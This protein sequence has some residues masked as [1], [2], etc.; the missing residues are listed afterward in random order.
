MANDDATTDSRTTRRGRYW[1]ATI[2]YY[3]WKWPESLPNGVDWLYGQLELG[4]LTGYV[5]WQFVVAFSKKATLGTCTKTFTRTGHFE[6]TR[7]DS[8]NAYVTKSETR[9]VGPFE[10][11][12]EPV[13]RNSARDWQRV[14]E[15]AINGQL[16]RI[17]PSVRVHH[18]RSLRAIQGDFAK[19]V[20]MDRI[21]YV[22]YGPTGTGKSFTAWSNAGESAYP[23]DPNT[24]WWSGYRNQRNCVIDEYRG[25]ISISH[26]LR[27]LDR[28]PA[29]FNPRYPVY[30]ETKGSSLPLSVTTFYITSN[31]HPKDWYPDLDQL[32]YAALE[33]RLIITHFPFRVY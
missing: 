19:P 29:L 25:S 23:K 8:A 33:R 20:P 2:P 31:L 9:I 30:V 15:Y 1:I 4:E 28:Y 12:S 7:S 18:Y 13:R 16:E 11:G 6:L 32:T 14:W 3:A 21:C 17:D 27:W 22:Y 26:L 10:L 5:H 24:K